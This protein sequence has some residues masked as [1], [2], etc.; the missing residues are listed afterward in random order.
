VTDIA[1][2]VVEVHVTQFR[3]GGMDQAD[4]F[5]DSGKSSLVL[6]SRRSHRASHMAFTS[7]ASRESR[8][9]PCGDAYDRRTFALLRVIALLVGSVIA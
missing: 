3:R 7:P 8:L 6:R 2:R 1:S 9:H 4:Q 5:L